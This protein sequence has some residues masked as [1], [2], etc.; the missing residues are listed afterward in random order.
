MWPCCTNVARQ[1][2]KVLSGGECKKVLSGGECKNVLSAAVFNY[3]SLEP[4]LFSTFN[5]FSWTSF[6]FKGIKNEDQQ[7]HAYPWIPHMLPPHL[8]TFII[9]VSRKLFKWKLRAHCNVVYSDTSL[10]FW[11]LETVLCNLLCQKFCTCFQKNNIKRV[12]CIMLWILGMTSKWLIKVYGE[13]KALIKSQIETL[14]SIVH[15]TVWLYIN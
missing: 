11:P 6:N 15:N 2:K 7:S 3:A 8:K 12:N 14:T 10:L 13:L 5:V 4:I 1:C 9:S